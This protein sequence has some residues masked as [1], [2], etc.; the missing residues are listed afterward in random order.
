MT[1]SDLDMTPGPVPRIVL[2][3]LF[4]DPP[5]G[6]REGGLI[7]PLTPPQDRS[8]KCLP[9]RS[10]IKRYGK[11]VEI[12]PRAVVYD[13]SQPYKEHKLTLN[14]S[15]VMWKR[16][17]CKVEL[18]EVYTHL[19]DEI[20]SENHLHDPPGFETDLPII[21]SPISSENDALKRAT[22]EAGYTRSWLVALSLSSWSQSFPALSRFY[23]LM[24]DKVVDSHYP[25]TT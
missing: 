23:R 22:T 8:T 10:L 9:E 4:I 17:M 2:A 11:E 25:E 14:F 6:R 24:A 7:Q 19:H 20:K 1:S 3:N 18:E 13:S 16:G 12:Q 5:W 21:F 15:A